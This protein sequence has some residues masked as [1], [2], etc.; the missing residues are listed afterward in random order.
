MI[1]EPLPPTVAG[2]QANGRHA[3]TNE[4]RFIASCETVGEAD[5]RAKVSAGRYSESKAVWA[6][7]WLDSVDSGKSDTTKA[8]EKS[9]RLQTA[10]RTQNYSFIIKLALFAAL[11]LAGVIGFMLLR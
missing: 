5:V 6:T 1:S 9:S 8:A 11:L 7:T 3:L 2:P 4:E 10:N